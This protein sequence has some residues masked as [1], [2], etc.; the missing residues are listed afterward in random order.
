[1]LAQ[2]L[3]KHGLGARVVAHEAVTRARVALLDTSGV[4]M[5]CLAYV[6]ISGSTSHLRYLLR[7]LR[8]HLPH[9]PRTP[10]LVGLWPTEDTVL[11]DD[12]I[13]AAVGADYYT[14]SLRE[15]VNACLDAVRRA[16]TAPAEELQSVDGVA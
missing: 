14:T 8:L 15:A 6:E 12:R 16:A 5:V 3:G 11:R 2:L 10:I 13:R 7:R 4:A 9:A 1:M